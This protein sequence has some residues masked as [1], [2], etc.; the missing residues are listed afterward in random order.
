[1]VKSR[2]ELRPDH[3]QIPIW[4]LIP[5]QKNHG[6]KREIPLNQRDY[7]EFSTLYYK[8]NSLGL[9]PL[10]RWRKRSICTELLT[11]RQMEC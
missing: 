3:V 4:F 7:K 11:W 2:S 9:D 1:M 6:A 5:H 10:S 8:F